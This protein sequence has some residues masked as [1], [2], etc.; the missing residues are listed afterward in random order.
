MTLDIDVKHR[1]KAFWVK[2]FLEGDSHSP[3]IRKRFTAKEDAVSY[4]TGLVGGYGP[5]VRQLG[6]PGW[7]M[8]DDTADDGYASY[9]FAR[10]RTWLREGASSLPSATLRLRLKAEGRAGTRPPASRRITL[11]WC[12]PHRGFEGVKREWRAEPDCAQTA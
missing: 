5:A 10:T 7:V 12:P 9:D 6:R 8:S 3:V 11:F 2:G 1:G 4:A